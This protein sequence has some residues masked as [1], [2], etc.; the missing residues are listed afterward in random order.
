MLGQ[1]R[2]D[3]G[4]RLSGPARRTMSFRLW[5][6]RYRYCR[7]VRF[8]AVGVAGPVGKLVGAGE[9]RERRVPEPP[10]WEHLEVGG[11]R[12]PRDELGI[13]D[14]ERIPIGVAV[15][16]QDPCAPVVCGNERGV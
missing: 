9:T 15:V 16:Y 11:I 13:Q 14:L 10:P 2:N 1:R 3:Y 5:V 4:E 7:L 8:R 12:R 6:H